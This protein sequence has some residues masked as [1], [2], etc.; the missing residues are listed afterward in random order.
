MIRLG[1]EPFGTPGTRTKFLGLSYPDGDELSKHMVERLQGERFYQC[2]KFDMSM[3]YVKRFRAA[4]DCG[5]WVGAWSRALGERFDRVLAIE[6]Q[7]E[8]AQCVRENVPKNVTVANIA[9]GANSGFAHI[10]NDANHQRVGSKLISE[11]ETASRMHKVAMMALDEFEVDDVDYL[12]VHV[13]GMELEALK[14]ATKLIARSK[15]VITVVV[16]AAV[17]EFGATHEDVRSFMA[18]K[19]GYEKLAALKPYEVWGPK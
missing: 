19:L 8:N 6:A 1:G 7:P 17:E 14:G 4:I 11:G 18:V 15:P 2:D 3:R 9:V 13:N 10:G 12:K 5:A 16:K